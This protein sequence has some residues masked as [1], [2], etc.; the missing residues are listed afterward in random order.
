ML[1]A[2]GLEGCLEILGLGLAQMG[3]CAPLQINPC[4][5]LTLLGLPQPQGK[6]EPEFRQIPHLYCFGGGL[7]STGLCDWLIYVVFLWF[8]FSPAQSNP[9]SCMFSSCNGGTVCS[10]RIGTV[11]K[12]HWNL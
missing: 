5:E 10:G 7:D 3:Q 9:N 6:A 8:V 1:L 4:L 11:Y 2:G 12:T